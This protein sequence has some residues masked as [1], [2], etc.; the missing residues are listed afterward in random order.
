MTDYVIKQEG[1]TLSSDSAIK[2]M[3]YENKVTRLV[4][5]LDGTIDSNLRLYCSFYNKITNKFFYTP[6]LKDDDGNLYV[7]IGSSITLYVQT[8]PMILLGISEDSQIDTSWGEV[9]QSLV[10]WSSREFK[11]IKVIDNFITEDAVRVSFP[12]IE[13]SL[14]DLVNIRNT[15]I[16]FSDEIEQNMVLINET[17]ERCE[18]VLERCEEI[19]NE[20][21]NMEDSLTTTYNSLVN[22]MRSNYNSYMSSMRETY[23]EMIAQIRAEKEAES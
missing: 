4:F 9:D 5:D 15:T 6:V 19:L 7:T 13:K 10:L 14:D 11:R 2:L 3:K 20:L 21:E 17:K 12:D 1:T 23:E 22:N 16:T 8:W 18:T